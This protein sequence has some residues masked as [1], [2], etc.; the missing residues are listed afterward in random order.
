MSSSPGASAWPFP[1]SLDAVAAAPVH[2][3]VLLENSNVRVLDTRIP[4]GDTVA[5]HT[6][7]WPSVLHVLSWSDV[8]RRDDNGSVVLDTRTVPMTLPTVA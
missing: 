4:P 3:T 7:R 2:H 8:V 5:L 6:H 1:D